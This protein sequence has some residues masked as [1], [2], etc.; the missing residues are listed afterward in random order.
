MVASHNPPKKKHNSTGIPSYCRDKSLPITKGTI[1]IMWWKQCHVYHPPVI[2]MPITMFVGGMV[3][4]GKKSH[5]L[6]YHCLSSSL[7]P[8]MTY[9]VI[10]LGGLW[11]HSQPLNGITQLKTNPIGPK[12]LILSSE[13]PSNVPQ[14]PQSGTVTWPKLCQLCLY[15]NHPIYSMYNPIEITCHN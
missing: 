4:I 14:I 10:P 9:R 1:V 6:N 11:H 12:N 13:S 3:T 5:C 15:W 2:T 7:L 8:F